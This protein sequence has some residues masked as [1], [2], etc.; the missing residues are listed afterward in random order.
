M[1]V[2][3]MS[4]AEQKAERTRR[5]NAES[6]ARWRQ[7]QSKAMV[8]LPVTPLPISYSYSPPWRNAVELSVAVPAVRLT[9][10]CSALP[11]A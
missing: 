8:A 5:L 7:R 6:Q 11:I 2:G 3:G 4:D 10:S 1:S 9:L